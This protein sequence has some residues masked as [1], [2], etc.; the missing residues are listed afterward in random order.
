[1]KIHNKVFPIIQEQ[2][3]KN[4]QH[5]L[6]ADKLSLPTLLFGYRERLLSQEW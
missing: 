1:M 5:F 2:P 4:S 3:V 6:C